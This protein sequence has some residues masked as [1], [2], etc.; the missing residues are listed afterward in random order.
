MKKKAFITGINGQLGSYLAELLLS[1]EYEVYGL[2]R[3]STTRNKLENIKDIL[4]N[5]K[6]IDG[7]VLDQNFLTKTMATI[8]PN[9]V[10]NCCAQSHVHKS[11]ELAV[12]TADVTGLG[13]LRVLEAIRTSGFNSKFLQCSTSELFGNTSICPQNENTPFNPRS[14]YGVSKLFAHHITKNYRESYNMFACSAIM[15]N[16]ESKR[17]GENFVTRKI[18]KAAIEICDGKRKFLELGNLDARRDWSH[19]SDTVR[20]MFLQMQHKEPDD[21]I[22]A[23]GETYSIKDFLHKTFNLLGVK[24][25]EKYIKIDPLLYRPA[26]VDLLC[27]DSSKAKNILGWKQQYTLD[28]IILE[29]IEHE[30]KV[31]IV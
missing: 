17:R 20:G 25:Y 18:I 8:K 29:M 19:A 3:Y 26:E 4:N 14:P 5:I 13:A 21:F 24:D 27:G 7:D 9:E 16:S 30:K 31:L 10:Y 12:Y 2:V 22:F 23:S 6:I 28:D 15:F 1:N 11:F